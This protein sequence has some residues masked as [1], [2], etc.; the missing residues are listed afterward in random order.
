MHL[1]EALAAG[2]DLVALSC[3]VL[4]R[5]VLAKANE[6]IKRVLEYK[7]ERTAM[8]HDEALKILAVSGH[9]HREKAGRKHTEY[10]R[11]VSSVSPYLLN[12]IN[13]AY[14]RIE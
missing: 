1:L 3:R 5:K 7:A 14:R 10:A 6:K 2:T 12:K 13:A 4:A 8:S 9:A 11:R